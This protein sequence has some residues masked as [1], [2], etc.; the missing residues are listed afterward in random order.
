MQ[1]SFYMYTQNI[2]ACI[3]NVYETHLTHVCKKEN[4]SHTRTQT[5]GRRSQGTRTSLLPI[6]RGKTEAKQKQSAL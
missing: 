6:A 1:F 4:T 2:K 3:Q 5:V